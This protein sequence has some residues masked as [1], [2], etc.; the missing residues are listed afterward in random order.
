MELCQF[1]H[2]LSCKY[3]PKPIIDLLETRGRKKT[4]QYETHYKKTP[5][6]QK[7]SGV[8]FNKSF[9]CQGLVKF[10]QIPLNIHTI[11]NTRL[12]VKKLKDY[13][14]KS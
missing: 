6:I 10:N 13:L 14:L 9:M 1:G 11:K 2:R 7:H 5:N 4:H 8:N 12:L 3:L